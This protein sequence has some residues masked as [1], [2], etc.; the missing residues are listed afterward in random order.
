[1]KFTIKQKRLVSNLK[2]LY[3]KYGLQREFKPTKDGEGVYIHPKKDSFLKIRGKRV[4]IFVRT[5][6][7][8]KYIKKSYLPNVD[9]ELGR[10]ME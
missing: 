4:G 9:D 2:A 6:E 5:D 1:M 8:I 7:P 3:G 10:R